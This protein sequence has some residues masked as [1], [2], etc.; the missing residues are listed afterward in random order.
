MCAQR[1]RYKDPPGI[2]SIAVGDSFEDFVAARHRLTVCKDIA[3]QLAH[4]DAWSGEPKI[5]HEIKHDPHSR[6]GHLMIEV[7]ANRTGESGWHLGGIFSDSDAHYYW[8]G[9]EQQYWRF[10]KAD[11]LYWAVGIGVRLESVQ[12]RA[13]G[14]TRFNQ[15]VIFQGTMMRVQMEY[16]EADNVGHRLVGRSS[17]GQLE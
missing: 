4:G 17:V 9:D 2:N 6:Y 5:Y 11:L 3:F 12:A 15:L 13:A 1:N 10:A 16:A 8:H 14:D 7:A